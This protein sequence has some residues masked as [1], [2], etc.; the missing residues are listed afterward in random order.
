MT[1]IQTFGFLLNIFG[2]FL[3]ISGYIPQICR[4][5]KSKSPGNN[6]L[7]YWII[8]T[9]GIFCVGINQAIRGVPTIQLMIQWCNIFLALTCTILILRYSFKKKDRNEN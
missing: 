6:S 3:L 2:G 7:Q 9:F 5:Y 1:G 8:M 4:V